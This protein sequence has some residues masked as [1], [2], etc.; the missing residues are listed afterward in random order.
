[1]AVTDYEV[2]EIVGNESVAEQDRLYARRVR[3]VSKDRIRMSVLCGIALVIGVV[4]SNWYACF[5][6]VMGFL[7]WINSTAW[8]LKMYQVMGDNVKFMI[9]DVETVTKPKKT[10]GDWS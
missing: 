6:I 7:S 1:M 5:W 8:M 2:S 4:M 3:V 9:R 10:R